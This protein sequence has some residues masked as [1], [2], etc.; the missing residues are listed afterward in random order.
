MLNS[1]AEFQFCQV[2]S[3]VCAVSAHLHMARISVVVCPS[4]FQKA[5]FQRSNELIT[6]KLPDFLNRD[7]VSEKQIISSSKGNCR[8]MR[9]IAQ[10]ARK[11][12]L[13]NAFI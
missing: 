9:V 2:L 7:P 11:T 10:F 5:L 13:G 1:G 6:D 3:C 12:R 4:A 8:K